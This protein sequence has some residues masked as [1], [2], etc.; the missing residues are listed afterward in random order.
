MKKKTEFTRIFHPVGQ[1]AFYSEAF[2]IT[3][4]S[5]KNSEY[6]VVYDCGS[7]KD[8]NWLATRVTS[9]FP[10]KDV[11]ILFLSHFHDDH[12]KGIIN[13]NPRIIILPLLDEW[14]KVIFWIGKNLNKCSI[15]IDY[16]NELKEMFPESRF[17]YIEPMDE[18]SRRREE[19]TNID[20]PSYSSL[21]N[22]SDSGVDMP[23]PSGTLITGNS[24][25][26]W[27]YIPVNPKL[28]KSVTDYFRKLLKDKGI[29]ESELKRLDKEYFLAHK[30]DLAYIYKEIGNPNE[31]SMVVY[32]GPNPYL[33]NNRQRHIGIDRLRVGNIYQTCLYYD[34]MHPRCRHYCPEYVWNRNHLRIGCLYMG[35]INLSNKQNSGTPILQQIYSLFPMDSIHEISTIQIPHH[36]SIDNYTPSLNEYYDWPIRKWEDW[37]RAM[38]YVI[39]VGESNP[40]GHPSAWVIK[41]LMDNAKRIVLVTESTASTLIEKTEWDE[42]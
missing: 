38:I 4:E 19:S 3:T 12:Y 40:Y 10:T 9:S 18:E 27:I 22:P 7:K 16:A 2:K 41:D 32:S 34:P 5:Q 14:D 35:D 8:K 24:I 1:G 13:L 6:R 26:D 28:D 17:I 15:D 20:S 11:D 25:P 29:E 37:G 30:K 23:L 42:Q 39:S 36:G 31:F 21:Q 33:P